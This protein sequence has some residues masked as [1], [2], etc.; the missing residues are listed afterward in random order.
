[1][2]FIDYSRDLS[3][4]EAT[5]SIQRI[6]KRR[7]KQIPPD[8]YA[9]TTPR[10]LL[11]QQEREL[12]MARFFE[13]S[14]ITT[15]A[16]KQ[17]LDLGCG[18]GSTLR[19]LLEYGASPHDLYGVD[20]LEDRIERARA[21]NPVIRYERADARKLPFEDEFFDFIFVFTLFSSILDFPTSQNV[22]REISRTLRAG[23]NVIWYDLLIDNPKNRDVHGIRPSEIRRLFPN[24]QLK[25]RRITLAP[26]IGRR[27]GRIS[28]LL[29]LLLSTCT[30]LCTHYFAMLE[31]ADGSV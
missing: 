23:G 19:L 15:L 5:N 27:I 10:E 25:G 26:P 31:K 22:A 18:K 8:R 12:W 20:L 28:S 6:Y 21:L 4:D 16:G 14:G 29:Y 13:R 24:F 30:P 9:R 2:N 1:M 7:D 3:A 17:I 11:G